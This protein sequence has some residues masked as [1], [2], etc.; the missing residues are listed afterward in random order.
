[1]KSFLKAAAMA[2]LLTATGAQAA[3]LAGGYKDAPPAYAETW[4]NAGDI[5]VRL[6]G[7][8]L[9][10][11]VSTNSWNG[12]PRNADV[13]VDT[14]GI[15]EIDLSYF[16]TKNIAIEAICCYAWTTVHT[17]GSI[18][19][20]GTLGDTGLI[21]FTVMLQYHFD[22]FGAFKPYLGV[23]GNYTIFLNESAKGHFRDFSL[24]NAGGVA[25]QA[26]F[27]YHL[28]G[29]WFMNVDVKQYI[30]GTDASV[31]MGG[32][33][34]TTHVNLDPTLVGAGIG[35]RFGNYVPLK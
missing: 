7:E 21:P 20:L 5:F 11:N 1:M 34:I 17:G 13:D 18:G 35:Y 15:P 24:Q 16:I 30:L 32:N 10:P 22:G 29:N 28:S 12:A 3:D 6:R 25:F 4:W 19:N 33:R 2:A 27:D 8:A 9:I 23:G 14:V 26:G 31:Y